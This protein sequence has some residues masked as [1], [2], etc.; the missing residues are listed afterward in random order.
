MLSRLKLP[1]KC[2]RSKTILER[3]KVLLNFGILATPNA[4]IVRHSGQKV[5][6]IKVL[7]LSCCIQLDYT[8]TIFQSTSSIFGRPRYPVM[9]HRSGMKNSFRLER[10]VSCIASSGCVVLLK[11]FH[12]CSCQWKSQISELRKH[13][14]S[15]HTGDLSPRKHT[16][17][18]HHGEDARPQQSSNELL[19]QML[20][21]LQSF[22]VPWYNLVPFFLTWKYTCFKHVRELEPLLV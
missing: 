16:K 22:G 4:R 19:R 11:C 7:Q 1:Q 18:C 6:K 13:I 9:L 17:A 14:H 20:P 3:A 8:W 12:H 10:F 15:N 5:A 21:L 2:S